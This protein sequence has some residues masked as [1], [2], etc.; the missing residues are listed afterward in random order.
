MQIY[1]IQILVI[2]VALKVHLIGNSEKSEA[3][4]IEITATDQK[5]IR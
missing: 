4:R 5:N 2:L 1:H 3:S